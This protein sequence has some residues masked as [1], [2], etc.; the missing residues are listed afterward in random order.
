MEKY[1]DKS[2]LITG[3]NHQQTP[4]LGKEERMEHGNSESEYLKNGENDQRLV[5][6]E[7]ANIIKKPDLSA[8]PRDSTPQDPQ[9]S[10]QLPIT[11]SSEISNLDSIT[12]KEYLNRLK[13]A[14]SSSSDFSVKAFTEI[15]RLLTLIG[16]DQVALVS[17]EA[18]NVL[19]TEINKKTAQKKIKTPK[20]NP[21]KS[22]QTSRKDSEAS[23]PR[24]ESASDSL[25]QNLE[26]PVEMMDQDKDF[27]D[28]EPELQMETIKSIEALEQSMCTPDKQ[29]YKL[30]KGFANTKGGPTGKIKG[31][32]QPIKY[33][34]TPDGKGM[35][36]LRIKDL[37][38]PYEVIYCTAFDIDFA[39]AIKDILRS[40]VV[41][42][43]AEYRVGKVGKDSYN[44]PSYVQIS[45]ADH[46][47]VFNIEQ[48][49]ASNLKTIVALCEICCTEKIKKVGHSVVEDI[50]RVLKYFAIGLKVHKQMKLNSINIETE[51]FTVRPPQTFGLTDISYRF[52]G[53]YMRKKEKVLRTGCLPTIENSTQM[54]YVALDA[55]MPLDM[56]FKYQSVM[57][58]KIE[59]VAILGN[60]AFAHKFFVDSGLKVILKVFS[61]LKVDAIFLND[62]NHAQIF[63]LCSR[64]PDRILITHDKYLLLSDRVPNKIPY[65][66][67]EQLLGQMKQLSV[68]VF[69]S[70]ED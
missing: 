17:S 58:A 1:S 16:Q 61:T 25:T 46:G 44:L 51:L 56:Y 47:Y 68:D 53:K 40:P 67:N 48:L 2:E 21:L 69:S 32:K 19:Q 64:F 36:V 23:Q 62:V 57:S 5:L 41:G 65:Y 29:N 27:D 42:L 6:P 20:S 18:A 12:V 37:R 54:E 35:N 26:K 59:P 33:S 28:G 31:K 38:S 15:S 7:K 8:N 22:E 60:T 50:E 63:D 4:K 34:P 55:L 39:S 45:T 3:K 70:D 13:Q 24:K 11:C 43:D 30:L 9:T 10:Q 66:G 14:S 49:A 52:Y